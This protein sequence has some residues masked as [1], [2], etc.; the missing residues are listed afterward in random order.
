MTKQLK[1]LFQDFLLMTPVEQLAKVSEIRHS[2][3]IDRPKTAIKKQK[4]QTKRDAK[5]KASVKTLAKKMTIEEK[6]EMIA[7]LKES[8]K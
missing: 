1:D 8:L 3:T 7:K 2:R 4:A 5:G 6:A